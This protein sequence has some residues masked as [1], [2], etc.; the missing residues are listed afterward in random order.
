MITGKK[1]SHLKTLPETKKILVILVFC[2][3]LILSYWRIFDVEHKEFQ[4]LTSYFNWYFDLI[5]FRRIIK[6]NYKKLVNFSFVK[7]DRLPR[8]WN[9]ETVRLLLSMIITNKILR[10]NFCWVKMFV[11]R[12]LDWNIP[13]IFNENFK[14]NR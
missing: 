9:M 4:S 10:Q 7:F 5:I 8:F 6:N 14:T 1:T 13:H 2:F 11:F 12:S 3:V